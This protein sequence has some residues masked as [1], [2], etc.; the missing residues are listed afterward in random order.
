MKESLR[1]WELVMI[2]EF[3]LW[4]EEYKYLN[5]KEKDKNQPKTWVGIWKGGDN[6][7]SSRTKTKKCEFVRVSE[8]DFKEG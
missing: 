5:E 2:I 8:R 4:I 7:L 6:Y 3:D 1:H